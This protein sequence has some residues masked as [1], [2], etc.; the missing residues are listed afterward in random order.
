MKKLLTIQ[1][2]KL[3]PQ[4]IYSIRR[5]IKNN[6][7]WNRTQLSKE[8]CQRWDWRRPNNELKDIACRSMLRKLH[9]LELISLP[10]PLR[11]GHNKRKIR[12]IP[13]DTSPI[14]EPLSALRPIR[15]METHHHPEDDALFACLL[16]QYHYL[17]LKASFVGENLRYLAYDRQDRPIGCLLFGSAAWKTKPRDDFI[18]WN[19]DTREK[20]LSLMTNNTRFL[21]LPWVTTKYLASHLLSRCLKRLSSDWMH[22]YGHPLFLV[23]TFVDQSRF[24]GT[25]YKAA[26]WIH[27]GQTTGRSRQ[28]RYASLQVPIKHIYVYP[29]HNGFRKLMSH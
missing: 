4:D 13:H 24:Q 26:N 22:R 9:E 14:R 1:G 8:I 5:L 11:N 29:L 17:G 7:S 19:P 2:R 23:E 21:I 20:N 6:P 18:G 25:C 28:D 16:H 15:L 3:R 12:E 10:K 27:I